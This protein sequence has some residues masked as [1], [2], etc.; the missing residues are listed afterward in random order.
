MVKDSQVDIL[1]VDKEYI[2]LG[3]IS[4]AKVGSVTN[5]NARGALSSKAIMF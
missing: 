2:T 5:T 4:I 1:Y 3:E